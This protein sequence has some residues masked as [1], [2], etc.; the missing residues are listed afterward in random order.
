MW[1]SYLAESLEGMRNSKMYLVS[2][3]SGGLISKVKTALCPVEMA[4]N[5]VLVRLNPG[6]AT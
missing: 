4:G 3:F 1:C 2:V 6:V 5:P